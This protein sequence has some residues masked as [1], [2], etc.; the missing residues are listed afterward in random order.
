M[1]LT[2]LERVE[3]ND[4]DG[5]RQECLSSHRAKVPHIVYSRTANEAG[6]NQ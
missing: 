2:G 5:G 4:G 3:Q 1:N 6:S